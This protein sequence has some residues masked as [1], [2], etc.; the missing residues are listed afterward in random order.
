MKPWIA[1]IMVGALGGCG[2]RSTFSFVMKDGDAV[3]NVSSSA[4][5]SGSVNNAGLVTLEDSA[6][7]LEM[8]LQGL[9]AGN[10]ALSKNAGELQIRHK[11]T[12]D[13]FKTSLGGTCNVWLHPHGS[14]NGSVVSGDL[15]CTGLTSLMGKQVDIT[16]GS[17]EVEI[18]DPANNPT[19]KR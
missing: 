13:T 4:D 3:Q 8:N 2:S 16:S 10:H 6:W 9:S 1:M 5:V 11:D 17:F 19:K 15:D 18:N 12:S 14:A 7:A